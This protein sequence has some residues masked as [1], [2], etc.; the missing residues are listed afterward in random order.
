VWSLTKSQSPE[1]QSRS[2]PSNC[3]GHVS[4]DRVHQVEVLPEEASVVSLKLFKPE[5]LNLLIV[6]YHEE[7]HVSVDCELRGKAL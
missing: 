2:Q 6:V 1:G 7:G 4:R 5:V 3:E